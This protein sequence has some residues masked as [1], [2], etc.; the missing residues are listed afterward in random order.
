[1]KKNAAARKTAAA[2]TGHQLRRAYASSDEPDRQ[3]SDRRARVREEQ[4]D[5]EQ[6]GERRQPAGALPGGREQDRDQQHVGGGE[7]TEEGRDEPAQRPLVPRVVDEVLRQAGKALAV[8]EPE[9]LAEPAG[10]SGVAPGLERDGVDVYEPPGGDDARRGEDRVA[11]PAPIIVAE[12]D[13]ATEEVGGDRGQVVPEAVED[14][15][16]GRI[17]AE[18][19]LRDHGVEEHERGVDEGEPVGR[20]RLEGDP[21]P[22]PDDGPERE[23]E[24]HLLPRR[25]GIERDVTDAEIPQPRH[26]Q[27]VEGQRDD[28][29]EER[30]F[31]RLAPNQ[32]LPPASGRD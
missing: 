22:P 17:A 26:R 8:I 30:P 15:A 1:M 4:P 10:H 12:R 5:R 2:A 11:D 32:R 16:R 27:V 29:G 20:S 31:R 23:C 25:D 13:R 9:L 7:R 18:P 24:Q 14:A 28:K 3:R 21:A 19:V 6:A